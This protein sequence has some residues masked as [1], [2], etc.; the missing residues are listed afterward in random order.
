MAFAVVFA[1][2]V[3]IPKGNLLLPF[4]FASE[5]EL[6]FSPASKSTAK[7][8]LLC[9][10]QRRRAGAERGPEYCLLLDHTSPFPHYHLQFFSS[11]TAQKSRVKPPDVLKIALNTR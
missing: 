3:V 6:G 5:V 9:P 2:L 4:A 8:S 10:E 1:F 11:K 7:R